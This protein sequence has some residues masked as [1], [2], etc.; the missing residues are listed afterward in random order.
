MT[1][2]PADKPTLPPAGD[3]PGLAPGETVPRRV[4]VRLAVLVAVGTTLVSASVIGW[5]WFNTSLPNA[6][7]VFQG[8]DEWATGVDVVVRPDA[9]GRE[10]A[11]ALTAENG[12][13][14]FVL[15]EQG[16]HVVRASLGGA[17]LYQRRVHVP[18]GQ[19]VL[20]RIDVPPALRRSPASGPSSR[21]AL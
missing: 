4:F 9:G 13:E 14:F 5:R 3:P 12:R 6:V 15:V 8:V 1:Q 11:G 10:V 21:P 18:N 17:L 2:L 19:G 16:P 7:I 20:I